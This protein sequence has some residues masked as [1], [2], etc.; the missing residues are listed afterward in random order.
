[1]NDRNASIAAAIAQMTP[2]E[3][4][5]AA[6]ALKLWQTTPGLDEW[7]LEPADM[8]GARGW[9]MR[10]GEESVLGATIAD[11]ISEAAARL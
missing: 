6:H 7:I 3:L 1:M 8:D 5:G 10:R 11:A 2:E 9:R 4:R